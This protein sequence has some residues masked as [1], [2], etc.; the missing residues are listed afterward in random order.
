MTVADVVERGVEGYCD[1]VA[2]WAKSIIRTL[3]AAIRYCANT[4][5]QILDNQR[6]TSPI[7][8]C[9]WLEFAA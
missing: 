1:R 4:E 6:T 9:K 5:K 7:Q 3:D 2:A 8:Q